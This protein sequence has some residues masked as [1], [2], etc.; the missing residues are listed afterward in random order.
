V[1]CY[2][3]G[4][5]EHYARDYPEPSKVPFP[6]KIPY[7][8]VCSHAFVANSVPQWI[9][10]TGATK[11]MVQNKAGFMEFHRYLVGSRTIVLGNDS[12]EDV[13]GVGTY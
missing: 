12:K 2:N 5:K 9:V 3:Y 8:T 11:H 7:V 1:K 6:T 4:K 13:L 10:D